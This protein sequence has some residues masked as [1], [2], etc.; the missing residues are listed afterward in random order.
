VPGSPNTGTASGCISGCNIT[1]GDSQTITG[2]TAAINAVNAL[3]GAAAT[4]T[5]TVCKVL[6]DPR[7]IC[8]GTDTAHPQYNATELPVKSVCPDTLSTVRLLA[9]PRSRTTFA[10]I[11]AI[12][13]ATDSAPALC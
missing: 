10:V 9:T 8:G 11:T 4:I 13:S 12:R 5:D 3:T 7:K 1:G 2:T 6:K